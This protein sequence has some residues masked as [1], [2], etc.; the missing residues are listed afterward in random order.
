M[1]CK[2]SRSVAHQTGTLKQS[3]QSMAS[4]ERTES[5]GR[6]LVA[7]AQMTSSGNQDSNFAVCRD[8]AMQSSKKGCKMLFLPECCAFIGSNQQE[9]S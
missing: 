3:T 6:C 1:P 5:E 7:V 9:V 8:L 4:S 2:L